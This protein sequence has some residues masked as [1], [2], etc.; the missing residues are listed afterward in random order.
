M[1]LRIRAYHVRLPHHVILVGIIVRQ[2]TLVIFSLIAK[3]TTE[4]LA[5]AV[6]HNQ[7]IVVI[8]TTLVAKMPQQRTV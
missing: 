5:K 4:L 1:Y 3:Q 2:S 7:L 8:M 6:R